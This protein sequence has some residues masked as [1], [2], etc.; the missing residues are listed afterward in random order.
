[1][2]I[3][4]FFVARGP[5]VDISSTSPT[6]TLPGTPFVIPRDDQN[7]NSV[8]VAIDGMTHTFER[9]FSGYFVPHRITL[10]TTPPVSTLPLYVFFA[11]PPDAMEVINHV[12]KFFVDRQR[13]IDNVDEFVELVSPGHPLPI[14]VSL[15]CV[16]SGDKMRKPFLISCCHQHVD[17]YNLCK[18][19]FDGLSPPTCPFC[20]KAMDMSRLVYNNW[21]KRVLFEA[22]FRSNAIVITATRELEYSIID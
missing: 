14:T 2:S 19:W 6:K 12:I 5:L 7:T 15:R 3:H 1:M 13:G 8:V 21:L 4:P 20:A 10:G 9:D 11:F 22:P 16:F 17:C 18:K